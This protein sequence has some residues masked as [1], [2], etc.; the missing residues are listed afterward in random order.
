MLSIFHRVIFCE[1]SGP[2]LGD[3]SSHSR[4]IKA[5]LQRW[6]AGE[7]GELWQEAVESLQ[8]PNGGKKKKPAEKTQQQRNVDRATALAVEGQYSRALEALTSLGL[9]EHNPATV[10][11]M[12]AKH[13]P[14]LRDTVIPILPPPP[15]PRA[16]SPLEVRAAAHSFPRGSAAG[17]S[18]MRPEHLV[19]ALKVTP[20]NR[21]EKALATLTKLVNL[22]AAGKLPP[23]A[24]PFFCGAKLHGG[25]KK[26]KCVEAFITKEVVM[27][28]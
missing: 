10:A 5:R 17:P 13:P 26:D 16:F 23:A 19:I 6:Q 28:L 4:L 15:P 7:C 8:K 11:E 14:P 1:T 9:V 12:Q 27:K 20:G 25:G 21:G 18:G 3:N 24:A 2:N 22:L